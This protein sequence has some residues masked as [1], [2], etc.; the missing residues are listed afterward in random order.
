MSESKKFKIAETTTNLRLYRNKQCLLWTPPR[1]GGPTELD[2]KILEKTIKM[3]YIINKSKLTDT[4]KLMGFK[5]L[6]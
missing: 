6:K 3:F 1:Y 4:W 5:K 2:R